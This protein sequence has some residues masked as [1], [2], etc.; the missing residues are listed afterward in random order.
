MLVRLL[1]QE[2]VPG[3]DLKYFFM[4]LLL[5]IEVEKFLLEVVTLAAILDALLGVVNFEQKEHI[6][7]IDDFLK[8]CL[9][10]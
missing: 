5:D 9:I 3:A 7:L 4:F 1:H 6:V 2:R 10:N 8:F